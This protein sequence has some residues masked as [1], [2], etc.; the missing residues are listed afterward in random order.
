MIAFR[1]LLVVMLLGLGSYTGLVIGQEGLEFLSVFFGDIAKLDWRGQFNLDFGLMLGLS[2]LWTAWRENFSLRGYGL[3]ALAF[4][5]GAMFLCTYLLVLT[6]TEKGDMARVLTGDRP[7][8][9]P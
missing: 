2:A 6:L 4:G 3:A 1:L 7:R 9:S 8:T 5:G